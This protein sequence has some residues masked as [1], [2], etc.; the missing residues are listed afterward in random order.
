MGTIMPSLSVYPI[1]DNVWS[2][3]EELIIH[4]TIEDLGA[5]FDSGEIHPFTV[6]NYGE[7][8]LHVRHLGGSTQKDKLTINVDCCILRAGRHLPVPVGNGVA[9][10]P[11]LGA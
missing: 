11:V 2:E 4:G 1:V 10:A 5:A 3:A 7:T 9:A 6:D 8:L